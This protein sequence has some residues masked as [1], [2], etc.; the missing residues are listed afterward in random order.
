MNYHEFVEHAGKDADGIGPL[1]YS[2]VVEAFY[3]HTDAWQPKGTAADKATFAKWFAQFRTAFEQVGKN[4]GR[5]ME[6]EL[7]A[8]DRARS[9]AT[10]QENLNNREAALNEAR[11]KISQHLRASRDALDKAR[12]AL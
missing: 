8:N 3:A 12:E 6:A 7:D 5:C 1:L 4:I 2:N 9:F 11:E 10:R